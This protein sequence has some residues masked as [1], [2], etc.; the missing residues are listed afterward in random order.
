MSFHLSAARIMGKMACIK[1]ILDGAR[2]NNARRHQ[3]R[4]CA[5]AGNRHAIQEPEQFTKQYFI[6]HF[7]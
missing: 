5:D 7:E 3:L 2:L 6:T 1:N 4:T